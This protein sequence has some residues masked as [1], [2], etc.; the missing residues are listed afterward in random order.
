MKYNIRC[1]PH[2]CVFLADTV[3]FTGYILSGGTLRTDPEKTR[4]IDGLQPW[5]GLKQLQVWY[6]FLQYYGRQYILHLSARTKILRD[7]MVKG[8]PWIWTAEHQACVNGMNEEVKKNIVLHAPDWSLPF[9]LATDFSASQRTGDRKERPVSFASRRR[10][11]AESVM[12]SYAGEL[13]AVQY[14]IEVYHYYLY[15]RRFIL[16]ADH[17]AL[18]YLDQ[19]QCRNTRLGR[20]ASML[21]NSYDC[22]VEYK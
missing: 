14:G 4:A 8:T 5:L 3:R 21:K 19:Q 12:C 22:T 6:G 13:A 7:L 15:G 20:L 2:K 16:Q 10:T 17:E 18:T 11:A 1:S 9:I